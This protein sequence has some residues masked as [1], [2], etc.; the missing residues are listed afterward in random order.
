MIVLGPR[1]EPCVRIFQL[2]APAAFVGSFNPIAWAWV[3]LNQTDRMLRWTAIATPF[4]VAG[5]AAGVPFGAEGV[6]AAFS[7]TQLVLRYVSINYCYRGNFLS[8]RILFEA[9]WQAT[10]ASLGAMAPVL[11]LAWLGLFPRALILSALL[12]GVLY[13]LGYVGLWCCLPGGRR[14]LRET[15]SLW[16][17]LRPATGEARKSP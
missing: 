6:A 1:W 17:D 14:A 10:V 5:F 3:S 9:T 7:I 15:F 11:A 8:F 12:K 4:I 13:A 2:L 16:R